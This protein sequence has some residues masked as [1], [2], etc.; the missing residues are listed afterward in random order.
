TP[1]DSPTVTSERPSH[2]RCWSPSVPI[3]LPMRRVLSL[4]RADLSPPPKRIRDSDS[5]TDL[6]VSSKEDYEPYVHREVGLR[7]GVKDRLLGHP[8][9]IDLMPIELGSFDVIVSMDWLAKYHAVIVCDEKIIHIPYEDEVL[10]I[11]GDGCNSRTQVTE[12]KSE[13]ELEEKRLKDVPV[14]Q[15]SRVYSK[16]NLRSGYHPLRVREEDISK[17]E[18]RTRYGHYEFQVMPIGL[19]NAPAVFMDLMNWVCK[20]YLDNFVIIFIDDILIYSKYK[21]EHEGHLKLILRLLKEGKLFAKLSK[22]EFWL[23]TMKFLGHVIDSEN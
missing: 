3:S 15:G 22:C 16:I 12:K 18:F 14:L 2:K 19:T 20:S 13:D 6:E 21:N 5:V 11:K 23:S 1:Y 4:I 7:V 9:D 17:M 10:I 8:F